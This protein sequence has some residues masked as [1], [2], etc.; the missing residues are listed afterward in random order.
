MYENFAHMIIH[1]AADYINLGDTSEKTQSYLNT[2]CVA[3]NITMLP[4]HLRQAA[5]D[6]FLTQYTIRNPH[7]HDEQNLRHDM[8]LLMQQKLALFPHVRTPIAH[9][10][11]RDSGGALSIVAAALPEQDVAS[12]PSKERRHKKTRRR[13]AKHG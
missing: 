10:T 8:E 2:A 4:V 1:F 9:A 13:R 3:W 6:D 11:F 5:L 7:A 12:T